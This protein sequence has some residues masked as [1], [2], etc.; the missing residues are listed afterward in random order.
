MPLPA[1]SP[2]TLAIPHG[3][4]YYSLF[5]VAGFGVNLVL[6]L[7]EGRRRG[8]P[9]RSWLMLLAC[10]TLPFILGTKLL[11]LST[12]EWQALFATGQLP[13]SEARSILGGALASGVCLPWLRRAF[14]YRR[15]VY[16]AFA[17]PLC[18][19]LVVQCIGCI[20]TGCCFG[21]PTAGG[22]GLTYAPDTLP[23]LVQVYQG[24]LPAGAAHSLPVH[25]T[26]GY[27]LLLCAGVAAVLGLTR[28]RAW[29][30][31]SWRWLQL[32]LLLA[33][34]FGLEFWRDP[35]GEPVGAA[36]HTHAGLTLLQLQWVLLVMAPAALGWWWWQVRQARYQAPAAEVAPL[37]FPTRNLLAVAGLLVLTA[38]LGPWA[39]N[40][41]EVV[42]IKAL[43]LAVLALEGGALL[44]QV[45]AGWQPAR[46][47]LPFGLASVVFILTSQIPRDFAQAQPEKYYTLSGSFSAGSFQREQNTNGGCGG[48]TPLTRYRHRY[49]TG[50]VDFSRTRMPG[51]YPY[52]EVHKAER[53]IGIRLHAGIDQETSL[54]G[55]GY[56]RR[57]ALAALNPYVQIDR[58]LLG[59]GGGLLVGALGYH[60][61]QFGDRISSLDLQASVRVG[62]RE[63]VYGLAEYNYLGYGAAN[64]QQRVGVG[65]G[66]GGSKWQLLAG[67]ASAKLYDVPTGASRWSG[68]VE[69][70]VRPTPAWQINS[71]ALFGNPNQQ[72]A[73]LRISRR[74]TA[75]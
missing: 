19:A 60:K 21:V 63:R 11:A 71:F 59:I 51:V 23:Y 44:F 8:Y 6:L 33:G 57:T 55:Y 12:E 3:P 18:V 65:T 5:Y 10:I 70:G 24:L 20:L 2:W 41:P 1:S 74:I 72:Q 25:P 38:W 34:R 13:A 42:V 35:A 48:A 64:P 73:G 45:G 49:A 52:G 47:A 15:H 66:L 29:P 36:L 32:G 31:G 69:A 28:N 14:G 68:F 4:D 46:V 50:T 7:W 54:S 27:A 58:P 75:R 39:L 53:T 43:L 56:N 16:D 62:K 26:Q 61:Y 40:F 67:V 22:W 37:N 30:G 17:L 9:V